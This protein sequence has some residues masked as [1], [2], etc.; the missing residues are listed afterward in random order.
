MDDDIRPWLR[1]FVDS[2]GR[3]KAEVLL[4]GAGNFLSLS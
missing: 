4:A 2:V 3:E 1:S